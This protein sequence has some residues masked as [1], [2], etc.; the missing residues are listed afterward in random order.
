MAMLSS[1]LGFRP[2]RA[3]RLFVENVPN[4]V[5]ATGSPLARQSWMLSNA[6]S[7]ATFACARDSEARLATWDTTSD[8]LTSPSLSVGFGGPYAPRIR[9]LRLCDRITSRTAGAGAIELALPGIA[10]N[11]HSAG[12]FPKR[13]GLRERLPFASPG[14]PAP[15]GR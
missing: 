11:P 4:P 2:R 12:R 13:A 15:A 9:D 10:A 14:L 6:A 3:G 8:F 5:I 7:T 1:V